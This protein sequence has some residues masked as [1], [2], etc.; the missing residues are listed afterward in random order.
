MSV[1]VGAVGEAETNDE[2]TPERATGAKL[3]APATV[4][5]ACLCG[6]NLRGYVF[7]SDCMGSNL[8]SAETQI[9][10]QYFYVGDGM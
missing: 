2:L 4:R 10:K 1:T 8:G 3:Q 6:W 7:R 9:E 5:F